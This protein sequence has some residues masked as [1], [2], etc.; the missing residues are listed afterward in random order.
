M[1]TNLL[2][3]F[4]K[5]A[6]EQPSPAQ[7]S[8]AAPAA[9]KSKRP[10][11]PKSDAFAGKMSMMWA[12]KA[13]AGDKE[14][15]QKARRSVIPGIH[16]KPVEI[17]ATADPEA[18]LAKLSGHAFQCE[19]KL[20]GRR[21]QVHLAGNSEQQRVFDV[22]GRNLQGFQGVLPVLQSA[23]PEGH[24]KELIAEG[25]IVSAK[26]KTA[27]DA[28]EQLQ[29]PASKRRRVEE[30]TPEKEAQ[31]TGD[32]EPTD[33]SGV[34]VLY[35]LLFLD[36]EALVDMPLG[37]RQERLQEIIDESSSLQLVKTTTFRSDAATADDLMAELDRALSASVNNGQKTL[38]RRA[39]GIVLKCTDESYSSQRDG[40]AAAWLSLSKPS[41]TGT[42]AEKLMYGN[43]SE[44]ERKQLPDPKE[45]LFCV[46]SARRTKTEEGR[47]DVL[48][49]QAQL[50]KGGV[51]PRWYVDAPS[52]ED[53]KALG[54]DAVVG[55][56]LIP[57]RNLAL[58]DACK[59]GKVCVQ[60]SD[61]IGSWIYHHGYDQKCSSFNEANAAQKCALQCHVSPVAAARVLL[62]KMR[63]QEAPPK[64]GGV[65]PLNN[66]GQAFRCPAW[67][68][69][70]FILGDFFVVDHGSSVRFDTN[71][72]LKEDYD[73]TCSHLDKYG[74]VLRY[75]RMTVTA[76]HETN[77]GGA[78]SIRDSKGEEERK[79]IRILNEKWPGV[80]K[81]NPKR[82][83]QVIMHWRWRKASA[84]ADAEV[85]SEAE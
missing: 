26:G 48:N 77:A 52:L 85:D 19:P 49:V 44:E 71:L 17:E 38:L 2:Q 10:R 73:F 16:V 12:L 70:N 21:V 11:A 1:P 27:P 14:G 62:A 68:S 39:E 59:E 8:S 81:N 6:A 72:T 32:A 20:A 37:V 28:D 75:N 58:E 7:S 23:L 50:R 40:K 83:N 76:K 5:K 79:N 69:H 22:D 24:G 80:F 30:D 60:V 74:S 42:E 35:D 61:D 25:I 4:S 78:C 64:L 67:T 29:T 9:A 65:Y 3:M 36:G 56:K 18:A 63:S 34:L 46:V 31:Q 51:E 54:L 84:E 66:L 41:Y 57:A 43:M 13:G 45:F 47:R 55:G 33:F 53:Y 82:P 15:A